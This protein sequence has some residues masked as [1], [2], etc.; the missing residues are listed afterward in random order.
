MHTSQSVCWVLCDSTSTEDRIIGRNWM[1]GTQDLS[2]LSLQ[3]PMNLQLLQN[4]KLT[5]III[6]V[7]NLCFHGL[8]IIES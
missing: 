3:L 7:M 8:G 5:I 1:K 2:L 4:K 6:T